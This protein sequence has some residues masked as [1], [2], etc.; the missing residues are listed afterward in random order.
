MPRHLPGDL[1]FV[2]LSKLKMHSNHLRSFRRR[3]PPPEEETFLPLARTDESRKQV[4]GRSPQRLM[5]SS[6]LAPNIVDTQTKLTQTK[7]AEHAF[8]LMI[9][10]SQPQVEN[11]FRRIADPALVENWLQSF[12]KAQDEISKREARQLAKQVRPRPS[13]S[14]APALPLTCSHVQRKS[15]PAPA[16]KTKHTT[17]IKPSIPYTSYPAAT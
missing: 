7:L 15:I 9:D 8:Q 17:T 4:R 6:T 5:S 1:D 14:Q 13:P 12:D 10:Y 11:Y 16:L 3:Q 2:S